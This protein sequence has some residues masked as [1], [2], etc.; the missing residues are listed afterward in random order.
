MTNKKNQG[1]EEI[2]KKI[3][4]QEPTKI[5]QYLALESTLGVISLL[6]SKSNA[7]KYLFLSDLEWLIIPPLTKKQFV[8]FRSKKNEPIAFVSW[9]NVSEEVETRLL[10]GSTKLQ[11]KDWDSGDKTYIMDV[12]SPFA[13]SKDVL[14]ELQE[15]H[16]KNKKAKILAPNKDK[17]KKG[18]ESKDLKEFLAAD[19]EK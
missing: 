9:A 14:K 19:L 10:S 7:H 2:A 16:L 3:E 18:F 1:S 8:V 17:S 11:P 15:K 5:P 13:K 4:N 12:I 6:A